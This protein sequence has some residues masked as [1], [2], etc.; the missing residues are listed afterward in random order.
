MP[1][2]VLCFPDEEAA[3][4][5]FSDLYKVTL[6]GRTKCVAVCLH[7][8][9]C[10][11]IEVVRLL[12]LEFS[13]LF[14]SVRCLSVFVSVSLSVFIHRDKEMYIDNMHIYLFSHLS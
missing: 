8:S 6:V 12:T 10:F 5:S 13:S 2:V 9:L 11:N 1:R 3:D 7:P 4:P 14:L